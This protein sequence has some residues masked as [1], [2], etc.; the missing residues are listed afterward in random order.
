MIVNKKCVV[1]GCKGKVR[2]EFSEIKV[3]DTLTYLESLFD[4]EKAL[5]DKKLANDIKITDR[6]R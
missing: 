4:I 3:I 1:S 5:K 6:H 2:S